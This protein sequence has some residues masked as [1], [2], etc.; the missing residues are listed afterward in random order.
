MSELED[1]IAEIEESVEENSIDSP[2]ASVQTDSDCPTEQRCEIDLYSGFQLPEFQLRA[3]GNLT[4]TWSTVDL[5]VSENGTLF[6]HLGNGD[7]IELST[8]VSCGDITTNREEEGTDGQ[9][10][11]DTD[12]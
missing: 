9:N 11:N 4:S 3:T 10:N 1:L 12:R 7:V 2:F 8:S 6:L 5:V